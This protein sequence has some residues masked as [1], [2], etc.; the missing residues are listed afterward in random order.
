MNARFT[1]G[2]V[3]VLALAV[4]IGVITGQS[5]P[6]SSAAAAP[7]VAPTAIPTP[8][9]NHVV[10]VLNPARTPPVIYVPTTLVVRVGQTVTWVNNDSANHTVTADNGAFSSA[11]LSRGE[12]FRWKAKAPGRYL[13][14]SYT[15]PDL[16]GV[17]QVVG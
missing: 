12:S 8:A 1:V 14:G 11:V 17:I 7:T 16:R 6:K 2:L 4:A 5:Q 15:D 10:I 3:V 9:P 13:Y